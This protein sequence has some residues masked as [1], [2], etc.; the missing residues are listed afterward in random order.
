MITVVAALIRAN[1]KILI[2]RRPDNVHLPGLWEFPGGKVEA[3]ESLQDALRREIREELGVDIVVLDEYFITEHHYSDKSV[4]LHFF[5]CA[6][7]NGVPQ[8]I[9]V[10]ALL[11]VDPSELGGYSFPEADAELIASL[12]KR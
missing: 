2:T 4:R 10:A 6:I 7:R 12:R 11:W 1:G 5:E 9:G 8:A 3:N